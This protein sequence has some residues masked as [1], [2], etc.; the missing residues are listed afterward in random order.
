MGAAYGCIGR[1]WRIPRPL[2][3][4]LAEIQGRQRCRNLPR[5]VSWPALAHI[6][7]YGRD[8]AGCGLC[9]KNIVA[10]SPDRRRSSTVYPHGIWRE[11][12]RP[13]RRP[14]GRPAL[15]A[16][17]GEYQAADPGRGIENIARQEMTPHFPANRLPQTD[18]AKLDWL[19]PPAA[20]NIAR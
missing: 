2:L 12:L 15:V 5:R 17:R 18:E 4:D 11:R 20:A 7:H 3:P 9:N 16:A 8:V 14:D 1:V 10:L 13:Y 6:P 19:R